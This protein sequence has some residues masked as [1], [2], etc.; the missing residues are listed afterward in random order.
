MNAEIPGDQCTWDDIVAAGKLMDEHAIP[1]KGRMVHMTK[2]QYLGLCESEGITP[3]EYALELY[4][5]NEVV[6]FPL[7]NTPYER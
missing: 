1:T 4:E 6:Q 2:K 5:V 7:S 3:D